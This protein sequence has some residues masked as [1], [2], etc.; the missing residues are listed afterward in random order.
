M[1][2]VTNPVDDDARVTTLEETLPS[3]GGIGCVNG[4]GTAMHDQGVD[5][6]PRAVASNSSGVFHAPGGDQVC[7]MIRANA[8]AA[9]WKPARDD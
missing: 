3:R 9:R 5:V 4:I 8:V 6:E 1:R 7:H 2:G